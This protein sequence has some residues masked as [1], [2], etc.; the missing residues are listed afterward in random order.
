MRGVQICEYLHVHVLCSLV[1]KVKTWIALIGAREN[2]LFYHPKTRHFIYLKHS[3]FV[4]NLRGKID[5]KRKSRSPC[6]TAQ[7]SLDG[8][9]LSLMMTS[10]MNDNKYY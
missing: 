5:F 10:A 7:H 8:V 6:P 3:C 9:F 4:K 2:L 1:G